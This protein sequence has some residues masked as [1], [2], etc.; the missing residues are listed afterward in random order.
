MSLPLRRF[1]L[2]LSFAQAHF[3]VGMVA[4]VH[5][6]RAETFRSRLKQWQKMGFP[7]GT[8][9]GKGVKAEYGATQV[10][11]LVMLVKL[12]RIGLTPER[13][14]NLIFNA[15]DR[16]RAGFCEAI[17]CMANAEDHLHYFL[18][19]LDALSDL[20]SPEGSDHMHT[21]VD[22]FT[23]HEMRLAWNDA[24]P[25]W[26]EEQAQQKEYSTFLLRNRMAVSISIEIDSLLVWVFLGL[27]Q[28][29]VS[30]EVFGDEFAAWITEMR[31]E[32]FAN[33]GDREHFD[34]D[35]F[36]QS[37]ALRGENFDRVE[38][39]RIALKRLREIEDG[40]S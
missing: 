17:I 38:A 5:P 19:Q 36:N 21:F 10:L 31:G 1:G 13:A 34:S 24:D 39:A 12:L 2:P 8:R 11:Q 22:V 28:L 15:W 26:S 23:D 16:M 6:D 4:G 18:I 25:D 33:F 37:V 27:Q 32:D 7:E 35:P 40:N 20:S 9:V 29:D 14:Q 30:P 3:L